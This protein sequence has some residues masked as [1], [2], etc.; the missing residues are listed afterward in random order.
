MPFNAIAAGGG[1]ERAALA[2][3]SIT[4]KI[5]R[6]IALSIMACAAGLLGVL[7]VS[8]P[9]EAAN[10]ILFDNSN[11]AFES[12]SESTS[13]PLFASFSTGASAF[14]L[15]RVVLFLGDFDPNDGGSFTVSFL[16]D[17]ST[18]P[19]SVFD[20]TA[21]VPDTV[22]PAGLITP[23]ILDATGDILTANTRYWI[24]VSSTTGSVDWD[25]SRDVPGVGVANEFSAGSGGVSA[26]STNGAFQMF[27]EGNDV[28]IAPTPIPAALPLF[29][30][31]LGAM[32]LF[33]WRRK[34]KT[35]AIAS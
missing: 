5:T 30:T 23:V 13:P 11:V 15:A 18:T 7:T 22:F 10:V 3:E 21:A 17:N 31:G 26:N 25:F 16:T 27:V 14:N 34:R 35:A 9:A 19:G 32:G 4:M 24:E 8:G 6:A 33:G 2:Q 1:L 12:G 20:S 29:V 28:A